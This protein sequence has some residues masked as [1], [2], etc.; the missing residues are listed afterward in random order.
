MAIVDHT[1]DS[2]VNLKPDRLWTRTSATTTTTTTSTTTTTTTITT[3]A[4]YRAVVGGANG[5][6]LIRAR[7]IVT[8]GR[9]VISLSVSLSKK[10]CIT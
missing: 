4:P 5:G 10:I 6:E 7:C 1:R 2:Q 9:A 3:I 8:Y